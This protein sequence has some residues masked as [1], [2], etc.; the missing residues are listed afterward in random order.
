MISI[1]DLLAPVRVEAPCGDDPWATAVLSELETL[2]AGNPETQFSKAEDPDWSALRARTLE[3]AATTKDLR[4]ASILTATL[5][6]SEGLAGFRA[7]VQLIRGYTEQFWPA[8]FP[9]LDAARR[10][11]D[12]GRYKKRGLDRI[13]SLHRKSH[14]IRSMAPMTCGYIIT[15][16]RRCMAVITLKCRLLRRNARIALLKFA[17]DLR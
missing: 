1:E 7:G 2:I 17:V 15:S 13:F 12:Q 3:V 9:L 11:D 4:V 10:K 5:L 14:P 8:V 16:D 6:R